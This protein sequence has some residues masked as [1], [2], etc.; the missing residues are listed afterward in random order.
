ME[1]ITVKTKKP[2]FIGF[3]A[4]MIVLFTMP[5]GHAAMII[6]EKTLG[7][8]YL[9]PAAFLLGLVG[10]ALAVWGF[11]MKNENAATFSGLIGGLMVWTGWIE[12][13]FVYYAHRYDVAPLIENGTPQPLPHHFH[14]DQHTD[15]GQLYASYVR[16]RRPYSGRPASGNGFYR[17]RQSRMVGLSFRKTHENTQ[18]RICHTLC[19]PYGNHLLDLRR[20][21]GPLGSFPRNMGGTGKIQDRN[22]HHVRRIPAFLGIPVL[23][24][25]T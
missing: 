8:S 13:T 14:G 11:Y 15:V 25:K 19:D 1:T 4:F 21:T 7:E 18:N 16:L 20:D 6:M 10:A 3:A 22:H 17:I 9:T 2:S 5:L 12:F 24:Q 23:P